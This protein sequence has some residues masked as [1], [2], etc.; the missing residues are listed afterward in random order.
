VLRQGLRL[1]RWLIPGSRRRVV[2]ARSECVPRSESVLRPVRR[3]FLGG[4]PG[5]RRSRLRRFR[6]GVRVGS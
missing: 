1:V 5:Q 4:R 2:P 3:F 6:R